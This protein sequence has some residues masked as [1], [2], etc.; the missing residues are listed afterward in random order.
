MMKDVFSYMILHPE[1][2]FNIRSSITQSST[3]AAQF[4]LADTRLMSIG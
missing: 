4:A 3:G 1:R 2:Q